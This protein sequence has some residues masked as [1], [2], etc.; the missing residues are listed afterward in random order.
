MEIKQKEH[1]QINFS[2]LP[3]G[4]L[5]F[6]GS[7]NKETIEA[8]E[9]SVHESSYRVSMSTRLQQEMQRDVMVQSLLAAGMVFF[10]LFGGSFVLVRSVVQSFNT[11]Q[12]AR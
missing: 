8:I 6:S 11:Q 2:L 3:N 4:E 7:P 10:L 5:K 12:V 9:K 1:Q